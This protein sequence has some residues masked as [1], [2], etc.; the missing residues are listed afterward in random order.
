MLHIAD[1]AG[2][3]ALVTGA[4]SGIGRATVEALSR[5]GVRVTGFDRQSM[6]DL[7]IGED[8]IRTVQGDVT[9]EGCVTDAVAAAIEAHGSLDIAIHCAGVVSETPLADL[10]RA[11]WDEQLEVNLT[12]CQ[13][14]SR[15]VLPH[16]VRS[17]HGRLVL[18]SSIAARVGGVNSGAAYVAS[19]GGVSALGKW[20]ARRY[21]SSGVTVNMIAPGPV[22]S[23]MTHGR[24]YDPSDYPIQRMGRPEEV[25]AAAIFLASDAAAWI[26]GHTLDVNGGIYMN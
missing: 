8:R 22:D 23:P 3:S 9:D 6:D 16:L 13:L 19:K 12:A 1:L 14:V 24:D 10:R 21:G 5:N 2:R 4:A 20:L 11:E 26:T 15:I 25:A 18:F 7:A 17:P